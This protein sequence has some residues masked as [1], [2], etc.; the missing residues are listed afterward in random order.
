MKQSQSKKSIIVG[1]KLNDKILYN[2]SHMLQPV[3]SDLNTQRTQASSN[4]VGNKVSSDTLFSH[5]ID[6]HN[7]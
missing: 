3:T 5:T 4:L 2:F 7:K 6:S 1:L